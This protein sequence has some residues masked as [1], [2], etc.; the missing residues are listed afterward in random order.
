MFAVYPPNMGL[1]GEV[2]LTFNTSHGSHRKA[3]HPDAALPLHPP[4]EICQIKKL[5][6]VVP[7]IGFVVSAVSEYGFDLDSRVVKKLVLAEFPRI[8]SPRGTP[9]ALETNAYITGSVNE[10]LLRRI[11][12]LLEPS[13]ILPFV[14]DEERKRSLWFRG[15]GRQM[16]WAVESWQS[17]S[18]RLAVL[19]R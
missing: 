13:S 10:N 11:E 15:D 18:G 12:Y 17:H 5:V 2:T 6:S 19:H 16:D 8:A 7:W 3:V 4:T 14:D 1:F 9:H